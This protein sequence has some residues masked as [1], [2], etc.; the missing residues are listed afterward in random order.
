MRTTSLYRLAAVILALGLSG[1]L[2]AQGLPGSTIVPGDN[3]RTTRVGTRGANFLHI[4]IGGRSNGLAGATVASVDGPNALF[5][6]PANIATRETISAAVTY[7]RL[8]GNSGI[9]DIAAAVTFPIGQGALGVSVQQFASGEM[10][11]TT[12]RA[13]Q[14]NDPV[15]PGNFEWKGTA[16]GAHYARNVTDRLTAAIGARYVQEGIDLANNSFFGF[17]VSTRFR[18]GLYGLSVAA[19]IMNMGSTGSFDGPAVEREIDQPRYNGQPTGRDLPVAFNTRDVQMPTTFNFG[20]LSQLYGDAEA[21]FGQNPNHSLTAE[22]AFRDAID[23]DL[24]TSIGF[25][26]GY[27]QRGFVRI[28][29]KWFNEQHAPW[30]FQDGL[31]FGGGVN[32]PVLGRR[33]TIDYG[34]VIMGELQN[35]QAITFDIAN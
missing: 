9:S 19:S 28:G 27:K 16:V 34:Y 20:L 14:G 29:K 12:E 6:N 15:F 35:N 3:D 4:P 33:L 23:T 32:L 30:E 18:T 24:Q 17:D 7:M 13:P 1:Q 2:H 11:R 10:L 8:Y 25:E 31:S 21:L 22:V 26:Y 5:W